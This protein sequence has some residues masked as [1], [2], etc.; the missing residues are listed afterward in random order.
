MAREVAPRAASALLVLCS[1][2]RRARDTLEPLRQRLPRDAAVGFERALYLASAEALLA[3]LRRIA[4][5]QEAVLLVG[6]NPGLQ[7]LALALAGRRGPGAA[8]ARLRAKFPTGALAVYTFEGRWRDLA[9]RAA[10]LVAF[11]RPRDLA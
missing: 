9:P 10:R 3:R 2:A 6:H 1:T 5:D 8:R 11:T 4:E 7:E